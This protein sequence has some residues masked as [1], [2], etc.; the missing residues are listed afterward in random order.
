MLRILNRKTGN[1]VTERELLPDPKRCL[2]TVVYGSPELHYGAVA[3]LML[4][5]MPYKPIFWKRQTRVQELQAKWVAC[6]GSA[7]THLDIVDG[8]PVPHDNRF[9]SWD[10]AEINYSDSGLMSDEE[11][12]K[13]LQAMLD[14]LAAGHQVF[15]RLRAT[16]PIPRIGKIAENVGMP[17]TF[18]DQFKQ[19]IEKVGWREICVA[20]AEE[21]GGAEDTVSVTDYLSSNARGP[22][23]KIV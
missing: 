21:L 20:T 22:A 9:D 10:M 14:L 11:T 3:M 12:R 7:V 4:S 13:Q 5:E 18:M 8:V 23:L 2:F 6:G 19:L 17:T 16:N 15:A 1:Y